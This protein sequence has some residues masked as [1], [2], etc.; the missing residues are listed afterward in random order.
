MDRGAWWPAVHEVAEPGTVERL[1][2][3]FM[4]IYILFQVLSSYRSLQNTVC[5]TVRPCWLPVLYT[6]VC[7]C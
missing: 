4:F 2:L 7:I 1:S 5:Y 6:A 3:P